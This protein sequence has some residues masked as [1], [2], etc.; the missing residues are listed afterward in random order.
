MCR[1]PAAAAAAAA[2][3]ASFDWRRHR[4]LY[5]SDIVVG[6]WLRCVRRWRNGGARRPRRYTNRLLDSGSLERLD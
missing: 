1:R 4:A 2:A 3:A 6:A 5:T